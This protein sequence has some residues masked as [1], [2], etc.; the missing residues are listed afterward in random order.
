[1]VQV[2]RTTYTYSI[3][4]GTE[5]VEFEN[6][7]CC[8]QHVQAIA[9]RVLWVWYTYGRRS[10]YVCMVITYTQEKDQLGNVA[11]PARGQ[12]NREN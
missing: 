1:M 3:T 4:S 7:C 8:W 5:E 12:L 10:M 11:S 9:A 6:N 2:V